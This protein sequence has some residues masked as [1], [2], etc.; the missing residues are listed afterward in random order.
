MTRHQRAGARLLLA[1]I[2][3]LLA[4]VPGLAAVSTW[5]QHNHG[6]ALPVGTI[7][8]Q[9]FLVALS[10]MLALFGF[11]GTIAGISQMID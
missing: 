5:I 7:T 11:F 4:G 9:A 8:V 10:G 2:P 6:P 3:S 1:A